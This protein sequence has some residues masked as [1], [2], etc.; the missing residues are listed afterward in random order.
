MTGVTAF[1]PVILFSSKIRSSNHGWT[2]MNADEHGYAFA[3]CEWREFP[4]IQFVFIR[5]IR[6]IAFSSFLGFATRVGSVSNSS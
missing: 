1:T 2:R 4:R 5:A 6:V 3:S